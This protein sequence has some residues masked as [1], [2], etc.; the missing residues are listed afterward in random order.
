[1]ATDVLLQQLGSTMLDARIVAWLKQE[2]ENVNAGDAIVEVETDK[3]T[4][5]ITSPITGV[6]G[7]IL[8]VVDE[9]VPVGAKLAII[10]APGEASLATAVVSTPKA[11]STSVDMVARDQIRAISRVSISPVA[12]RL[13]DEHGIDLTTVQGS[14]PDGRI[15]KEDIEALIAAKPLDSSQTAPLTAAPAA[16]T[17]DKGEN[18]AL[19]GVRR[20]IAERMAQSFATAPH[21]YITA[22]ID[23]TLLLRMRE[24]LV[25]KVEAQTGERL[26]ITDFLIKAAADALTEMPT[27]NVSWSDGQILRHH[28]VNIGLAVAAER[29]LSVPVLRN[30][31]R[32]TL[33]Q[34]VHER[35][36]LVQK[37]RTGKLAL[38]DLDGGS[39]TLS[40]LGMYGVDEFHAILNPPQS[41]ILAAGAIKPRPF[42]VDGKLS[43]CPTLKLSLSVDHRM[44]DGAEAAQYLQRVAHLLR[45]P[46]LI[47]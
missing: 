26:S 9:I 4:T 1:M 21:F 3:V 7:K 29:G 23:A 45:E 15:V 35:A 14:G 18:V 17:T 6:L 28:E 11:D 31:N 8:A 16:T 37:V 24:S 41:M 19:S 30:V 22:E 47:L 27:L 33:G 43:A 39:L 10:M 13:A 20:I 40:N 2:W 46:Q 44:I 25:P 12:R 42:V 36:I 38:S 34:L 5:E 32:Q